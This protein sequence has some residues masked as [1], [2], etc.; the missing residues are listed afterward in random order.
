MAAIPKE[1]P[2]YQAVQAAVGIALGG[3]LVP[4]DTNGVFPPIIHSIGLLKDSRGVIG[5]VNGLM[6]A[7]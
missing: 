5:T 2:N 4:A 1:G 6:Q 7:V 3:T